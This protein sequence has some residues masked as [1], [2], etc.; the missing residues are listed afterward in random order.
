MV[1]DFP[2]SIPT[3]VHIANLPVAQTLAPMLNAFPVGSEEFSVVVIYRDL[4][5]NQAGLYAL[6]NG[7]WELAVPYSDINDFI[8]AGGAIDVYFSLAADTDAPSGST[9]YRNGVLSTATTIT[10]SD[11]ILWAAIKTTPTTGA[12]AG[13]DSFNGRQGAV[14]LSQADV[15]AVLPAATS[16]ALGGVKIGGNIT[17]QADG[18]IS[19]AAPTPPYT[20][21][22]A[23]AT[24]LGGVKIGANVT[25]A[26]DGT[27]SVAAPYTLPVSSA[28]VLGGV[29]VG[30]GIT[31]AGD[32]TIFL[33][34]NVSPSSEVSFKSVAA[35]YLILGA[36]YT[37]AQLT[38][39]IGSVKGARAFISDGSDTPQPVGT[40]V[41]GTTAGTTMLPVYFDG[42]DWRI[43]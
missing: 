41:S 43:G 1:N 36:T 10:A 28:T 21:P 24:V 13:V 42:T 15:S 6:F 32:G 39:V 35:A 11:T 14:T 27:I 33:Q 20:L 12:A 29:K 8:I 9:V 38:T 26:G 34:Q 4:G 23:S 31:V 17:V 19:V 18:T 30:T 40:L 7:R 5:D 25:V 16:T 2:L 3:N 22:A 37:T